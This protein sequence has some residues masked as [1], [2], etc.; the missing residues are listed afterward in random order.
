M[1]CT[2]WILNERNPNYYYD[3]YYP[4]ELMPFSK[5]FITTEKINLKDRSSPEE[6]D[7]EE[8]SYNSL[9]LYGGKQDKI[10]GF[11]SAIIITAYRQVSFTLARASLRICV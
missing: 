3:D 1:L 8:R 7:E 9:P 6:G 5:R 2:K 4:L 10:Y 11:D